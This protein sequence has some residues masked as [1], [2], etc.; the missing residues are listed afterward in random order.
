METNSKERYVIFHHKTAAATSKTANVLSYLTT[1][2]IIVT[3]LITMSVFDLTLGV[4]KLL[5]S[6]TNDISDAIHLIDSLKISVSG[7]RTNN[8]LNHFELY[9]QVLRSMFMI[10]NQQPTRNKETELKPQPM[11]V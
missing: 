6:K 9:K 4:T 3:M 10:P 7:I 8:D 5:Q 11:I 2:E 1:F